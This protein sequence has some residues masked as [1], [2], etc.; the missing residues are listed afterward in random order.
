MSEYRDRTVLFERSINLEK[1][2]VHLRYVA[3]SV[4]WTQGGGLQTGSLGKLDEPLCPLDGS[5]KRKCWIAF[6]DEPLL[7]LCYLYYQHIQGSP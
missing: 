3:V 5:G 1:L 2:F 7:V 4:S 6:D